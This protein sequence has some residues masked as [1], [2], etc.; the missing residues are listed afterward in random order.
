MSP[1]PVLHVP[2][3]EEVTASLPGD[4]QPGETVEAVAV[5]GGLVGTGFF[6]CGFGGEADDGVTVFEDR[7]GLVGVRVSGEGE[8]GDTEAA[9]CLD[10][11]QVSHREKRGGSRGCWEGRDLEDVE[12]Q[13]GS[14]GGDGIYGHAVEHPGE[15]RPVPFDDTA[16][17]EETE[18]TGGGEEGA[19][20]EGDAAILVEMADGLV[21]GAG[22]VDVG[23]FVGAEDGEGGRGQAFGGEVDVLACQGG[24][25][26]EEDG[27]LEAPLGEV[28]VEGGIVLD[29]VVSRL[30]CVVFVFCLLLYRYKN[31]NGIIYS[32]RHRR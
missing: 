11:G 6:L 5:V 19:E 4:T 8:E 3:Q 22:A 20:H 12:V 1:Q 14:G 2:D 28:I 23:S 9:G 15:L 32:I 24:G 13:D 31:K 10:L 30:Y 17:A 16:G 21:A 7:L 29:H 25:R 27:L 18:D 26:D